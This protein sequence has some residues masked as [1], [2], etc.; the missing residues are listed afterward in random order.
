MSLKSER[1]FAGLRSG[2]P[3]RV[4]RPKEMKILFELRKDARLSLTKMSRK[5]KV[6]VS[7]IHDKLKVYMNGLI[8]KHTAIL[9]FSSLG[10]HA[11][12]IVLFKVPREKRNEFKAFL[13]R[14]HN[15]NSVYRVNNGFDFMAEF[16]FHNVKEMEDYIEGI[17][18]E[19]GIIDKQVYY[20]VD[21]VCRESFMAKSYDAWE[22]E[23]SLKGKN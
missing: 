1:S 18:S 15:V 14:D 16:V 11:R 5:I 9:N 8:V 12:S 23:K 20:M 10:Y 19:F 17:E 21:D 2:S 6:P 13:S 3:A 7:T 22:I 4:M